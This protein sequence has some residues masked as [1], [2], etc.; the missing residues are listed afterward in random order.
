MLAR[1]LGFDK[2]V[3]S[4]V[5]VLNE[6]PHTVAA[7]RFAPWENDEHH[8]AFHGCQGRLA[9]ATKSVLA[10]IQNGFEDDPRWRT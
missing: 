1:A 3:F 10:A 8:A 6:E 2:K 4:F 9:R 7:Y 5:C